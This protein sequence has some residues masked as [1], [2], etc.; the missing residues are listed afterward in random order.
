MAPELLKIPVTMKKG[1]A[2]GRGAEV[3][4]WAAIAAVGLGATGC[5]SRGEMYRPVYSTGPVEAAAV[6]AAPQGAVIVEQGGTVAAPPGTVIIEQQGGAPVEVVYAQPAAQ[7]GQWVYTNAGW[8]WVPTAYASD[9][10]VSSAPGRVVWVGG[11][12]RQV[13]VYGSAGAVVRPRVHTVRVYP[14]SHRHVHVA[15]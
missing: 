11:P 4:L 14:H 8:A 3:W 1:N 5:A 12:S 10:A 13:V 6:P 9:Q 15:V 7:G 2:S